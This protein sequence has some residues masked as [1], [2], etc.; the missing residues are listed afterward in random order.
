MLYRHPYCPVTS[1]GSV[2][3]AT[4]PTS[5][6]CGLQSHVAWRCAPRG[7]AAP[8]APARVAAS[9]CQ[10][11]VTRPRLCLHSHQEVGAQHGMPD[12]HGSALSECP[13]V[14][15]RSSRRSC[16]GHPCTR[17]QASTSPGIRPASTR[18]LTVCSSSSAVWCCACS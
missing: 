6:T 1:A 7:L 14:P 5:A 10:G 9:E 16:R 12:L 11:L 18:L 3:A 4:A 13:E 15:G 2:S 17:L 8:C